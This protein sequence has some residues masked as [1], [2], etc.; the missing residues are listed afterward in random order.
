[1]ARSHPGSY[2]ALQRR[3]RAPG[4]MKKRV[5]RILGWGLFTLGVMVLSGILLADHLTPK[6]TGE[7]SHAL[8]V[9]P[10]ETLLVLGATLAVFWLLWYSIQ[11]VTATLTK[12]LELKGRL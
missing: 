3:G 2:N 10:G 12:S 5:K 8:P 4:D 6:A 1:M 11:S 7:P 9:Q